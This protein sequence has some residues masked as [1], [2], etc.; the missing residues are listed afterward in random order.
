MT[1]GRDSWEIEIAGNFVG[2]E[3]DHGYSL[4]RQTAC[5]CRKIGIHE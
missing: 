4:C 3:L 1:R 2:K 5:V